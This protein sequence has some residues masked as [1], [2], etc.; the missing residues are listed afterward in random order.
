MEIER[1]GLSYTVDTLDGV[2]RATAVVR[3]CSGWSER[4]SLRIVRQVA[5]SGA[6]R[7]ACDRRS[8]PAHRRD[9]RHCLV[10]P[11]TPQLLATRRVDISS[12]EI[13]QRVR[14][15]KVDSRFRARCRR[16][17]HRGGRAVPIEDCMLKRVISAVIGT[18][19]ERER[20]NDS[21]DRRR[22]QRAIRAAADA[23]PTR[24]CA[25]RPRS[26]AGSFASDRRARGD[27]SPTLEGAEAH[28]D[29][30][31][32]AR[33]R[34]TASWA[35]PT[36]AAASKASCAT[37]SPKC[38]TRSCPKRSPRCAKRRA[39]CSGRRSMVTGQR[40]CRGTW[41][42]TTC[43]SWAASS[44][45]SASIA[46]MATGE[47]K[48]LVATLPLYLNALPGKGAHLVTVNSY[49]AR[50]DSQWMG[51]VYTYLGLTVGCLDDTEPGTPERRAAYSRDI[52]YGTNNEFGFD[53]LR[54]NMVRVA[55]PAR[56]AAARRTRSSTKWTRCSST[57]RERRSSSPGPVGNENDGDVLRA[58]RRGRAARAP[59]DGAREHA[60][61]R[62]GARRSRRATRRPPRSVCTRR[63]SAARRTG[64]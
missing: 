61:R 2:C 55:R 21:A 50:R 31:R 10:S 34:S 19:H 22:D 14:E 38:S 54:D 5:Q 40:A 58:Q 60:R 57:K 29:R 64:A 23:S 8:A 45:T 18:R 26:S 28:R 63:S 46:E 9:S 39:A 12:T 7:R 33:A 52:T 1:G 20:K 4:T 25:A 62:G 49:L 41:C 47:G 53:Y 43:S 24:S 30:S 16:R 35:A 13:R 44:C 17:V 48:T 37:R 42:R 56:A 15:G 3:S 59:A 6:N 51:H 27:A 36:A 11:D 32:R